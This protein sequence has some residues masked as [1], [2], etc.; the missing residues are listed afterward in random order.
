MDFGFPFFPLDTTKRVSDSKR[1]TD[2]SMHSLSH[3]GLKGL[4]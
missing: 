4:D 1:Q 2:P 3:E